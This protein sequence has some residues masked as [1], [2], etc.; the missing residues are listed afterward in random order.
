VLQERTDFAVITRSA[1]GAL[2]GLL[3]VSVSLFLT[4]ASTGDPAK[5]ASGDAGD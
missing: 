4:R 5:P 2:T 1:A 3:F